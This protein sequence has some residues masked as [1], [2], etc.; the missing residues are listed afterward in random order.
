MPA[1]KPKNKGCGSV[2]GAP[3]A[4]GAAAAERPETERPPS[5]Q[6]PDCPHCF[7]TGMYVPP[8]SNVAQRCACQT[9][10][11]RQ[12][13]FRAAHIPPRYQHCTLQ[14]YKASDSET[15]K[16]I[17]NAEAHRILHDYL[18]FHGPGLAFTR[19]PVP[20]KTHLPAAFLHH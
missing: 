18:A 5:V 16:W 14:D 13:L 20:A 2:T 17:A 1:E 12:R 7:G 10:D 3:D 9:L 4:T 6:D 15:S 8:G 11:Q 19:A